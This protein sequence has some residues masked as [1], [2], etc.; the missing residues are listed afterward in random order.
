MLGSWI[1]DIWPQIC[2]SMCSDFVKVWTDVKA[3]SLRSSDGLWQT[4]KRSTKRTNT[5]LSK[6]RSSIHSRSCARNLDTKAIFRDSYFLKLASIGS[7]VFHNFVGIICVER[8]SLKEDTSRDVINVGFA[9]EDTDSVQDCRPSLRTVFFNG[10][11]EELFVLG[12]RH[13]FIDEEL[14][15]SLVVRCKGEALS[16]GRVHGVDID[17]D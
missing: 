7:S 12:D 9:E 16:E 1:F 11:E 2:I 8:R 4:E 3:S 13:L 14:V 5:F 6:D 15:T 10:A 17:V